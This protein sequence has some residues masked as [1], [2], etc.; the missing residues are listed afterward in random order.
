MTWLGWDGRAVFQA[1][2]VEHGRLSVYESDVPSVA[3]AIIMFVVE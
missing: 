3:P 2:H 1:A